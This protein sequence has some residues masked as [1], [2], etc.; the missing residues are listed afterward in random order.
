MT[1]EP[2]INL[3]SFAEKPIVVRKREVQRRMC[4]QYVDISYL[5]SF[6]LAT[7]ATA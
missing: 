5:L 1:S 2:L 3:L 7:H 4:H 6:N